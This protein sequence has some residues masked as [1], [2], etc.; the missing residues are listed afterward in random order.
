M[1]EID[2]PVLV[3]SKTKFC[4]FV[5]ILRTSLTD[6]P[7]SVEVCQLIT[8]APLVYTIRNTTSTTNFETCIDIYVSKTA[9]IHGNTSRA[10]AYIQTQPIAERIT[11]A[12]ELRRARQ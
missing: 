12:R 11:I 4:Q 6:L 2:Y 7:Y 3:R 9:E 8:T 1:P 5:R 10:E